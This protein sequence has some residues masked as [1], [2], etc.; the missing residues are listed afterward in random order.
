MTAKEILQGMSKGEWEANGMAGINIGMKDIA[1][2]EYNTDSQAA[3]TAVNASYLKGYDPTQMDAM[4]KM[5]ERLEKTAAILATDRQ[6]I[7][8]LLKT[9]KI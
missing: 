3:A 9:A 4:Y 8:E 1:G 7:V 5:L 6:E 2:F